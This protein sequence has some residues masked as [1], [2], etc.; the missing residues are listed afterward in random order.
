MPRI[1]SWFFMG[2]SNLLYGWTSDWILSNFKLTQ[3]QEH[4]M[5]LGLVTL[6]C[7]LLG[8][9]L[10]WRNN[11]GK[12]VVVS[13]LIIFVVSLNFL[14]HLSLWRIVQEIYPGG[15]SIRAVCRV[16]LLLLIVFS[17]G[18]A[19]FLDQMKSKWLAYILAVVMCS[20]Q[21]AVTSSYDKKEYRE[22][23]DKIVAL[24][25]K[26]SDAFYYASLISKEEIETPY[27]CQLD[28]M[29]AQIR[30]NRPTLNGYS[31]NEPPGW[32]LSEC[33]VK[34][35]SAIDR[36]DRDLRK[37]LE[38]NHASDKNIALVIKRK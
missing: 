37:W 15:T 29:W 25:P 12:V 14:G 28:A 38:K 36:L 9:R 13:T 8:F 19:T 35:S 18:V 27:G 3:I 16:S 24:I 23:I 26:D 11:W 5:G 6:L 2:N 10:M 22:R 32:P 21:V 17:F 34:S 33:L 31:G 20:E 1:Q 4:Q 30:V 7:S